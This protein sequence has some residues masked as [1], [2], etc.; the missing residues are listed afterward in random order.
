MHTTEISFA[1]VFIDGVSGQLAQAS[2]QGDGVDAP[3]PTPRF[4]RL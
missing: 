3:R 4:A 2:N 1:Q